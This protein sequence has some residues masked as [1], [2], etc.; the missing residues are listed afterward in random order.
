M[1]VRWLCFL[2]CLRNMTR[3]SAAA[4]L[5]S[6]VPAAMRWLANGTKCSYICGTEDS[7]SMFLGGQVALGVDR[8]LR[9]SRQPPA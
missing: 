9:P 2:L 8:L 7:L 4:C 1:S 3:A 6:A 5:T